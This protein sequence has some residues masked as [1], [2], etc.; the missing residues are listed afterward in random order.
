[1]YK[2]LIADKSEAFCRALAE[3]MRGLYEVYTCKDGMRAIEMVKK[4]EPEVLVLDLSLP[5]LDGI[6][7]LRALQN[8][9]HH[10]MVLAVTYQVTNYILSALESL[11][12]SYIAQK[13]CTIL[14]VAA[15]LFEFHMH[16]SDSGFKTW[17]LRDEAYTILLSLGVSLCGKNF[18]CIHEA[19]VYTTEHQNSFVTKE[20]YPAIAA[21]CGGTPKRV[22]KAIR[23]AIE[24]AWKNRDDRVWQ[25]YFTYGRDGT[26]PCPSNGEFLS[27]LAYYL[28]RRMMAG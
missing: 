18:A 4:I 20:L 12:V 1:M 24:K 7:V 11:S 25:L 17:N 3:Q 10:P 23:D 6:G 15:R 19:L 26:I 13:P 22:E 5:G 8:S 2:L 9:G 21:R 14:N 27:R 16:L 28:H